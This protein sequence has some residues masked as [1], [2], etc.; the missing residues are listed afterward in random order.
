MVSLVPGVFTTDHDLHLVTA[1]RF[2][3]YSPTFAILAPALPIPSSQFSVEDHEL[4]SLLQFLTISQNP[5]S[6][7]RFFVFFDF[8]PC[9]FLHFST[10]FLIPDDIPMIWYH[11]CGF[12]VSASHSR[13]QYVHMKCILFG[14][15][16]FFRHNETEIEI[17][18]DPDR[19]PGVIL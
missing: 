1:I 9:Y 17:F 5:K 7:V 3:L 8:L 16:R 18:V 13:P 6:N 11:L 14:R 12:S 2:S 15:G 19:C 10:P 4:A